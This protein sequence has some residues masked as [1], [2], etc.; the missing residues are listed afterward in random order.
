MS[1]A[2][3]VLLARYVRGQIAEAAWHNLMQAFD[4]DEI[5]GPE[6]LA[7]ARFVNDL[8]SERGAQAEIPRLEEIQDLLAETRI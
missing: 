6:R 4:A 1:S 3:A 7:L 8:L 5:S 2:L